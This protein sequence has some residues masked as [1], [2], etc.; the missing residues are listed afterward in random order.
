MIINPLGPSLEYYL[1]GKVNFPDSI[2]ALELFPISGARE[3]EFAS[4]EEPE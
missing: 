1:N 3:G 4:K 2:I